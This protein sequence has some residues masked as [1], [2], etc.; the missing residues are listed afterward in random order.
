MTSNTVNKLFRRLK[1]LNEFRPNDL[2][3][4]G[5]NQGEFASIFKKYF[6][7]SER[8]LLIEAN[9]ECDS[10]LKILPFDYKICLLSCT[11]KE[12]DFYFD[13]TSDSG[14]GNSY[15]PQNYLSKRFKKKPMQTITLDSL[16]LDYDHSFGF[17][18]LD[19]QG[20]ELDILLGGKDILKE[21]E[22]VLIE[23]MNS[24]LKKYNEGSPSEKE[25]INFMR[26]NGFPYQL[27]VDEHIWQDQKDS[28]Y[29][30]KFG[31]V[32]QR[33]YLFSRKRLKGKTLLGISL[34]YDKIIYKN[35][36]LFKIYCTI[37]LFF[38]NLKSL[39]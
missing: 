6:P 29:R 14:S 39:F 8:L 2:L 15:Y 3:D 38:K 19:T 32:F 22:F 16:L 11:N 35:R 21:A 18:K 36:I 4:I 24:K 25:V 17:I 27:I 28:S 34:F 7:S 1:L 31:T 13:P 9:E 23:C 12:V 33:D 30:L 26:S 37:K 20:S 10:F 5:A